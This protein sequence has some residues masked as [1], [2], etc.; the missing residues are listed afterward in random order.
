MQQ[1]AIIDTR[2]MTLYSHAHGIIKDWAK[3][4]VQL[5]D[6]KPGQKIKDTPA[7]RLEPWCTVAPR[8]GSATQNSTPY[9]CVISTRT[10][11]RVPSISL[12]IWN[13]RS[14]AAPRSA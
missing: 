7:F 1:Q 11:P 5:T 13:A 8:T 12:T 4:F 6:Q 14:A 2:R 9:F 10:F 3:Q